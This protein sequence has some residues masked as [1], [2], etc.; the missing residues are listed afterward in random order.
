MMGATMEM[1]EG[2]RLEA[3]RRRRFWRILGWL[4]FAGFVA[5]VIFGGTFAIIGSGSPAAA[6]IPP[7]VIVGAVSIA[8]AGF[9]YGTWRFLVSADE[10]ERQDNL[11]GSLI[12]FYAYS[13]I[14]PFWWLLWK[15]GVTSE[16]HDWAIFV[17]S[18]ISATAVYFWRKWRAH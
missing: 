7:V 8:V 14:F 11:W 17:I 3:A 12:G 10:I 2:E 15:A 13:T 16:P 4:A 9:L 18:L 5:G 6:V 1:G